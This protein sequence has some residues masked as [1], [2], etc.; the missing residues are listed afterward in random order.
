MLKTRCIAA[1]VA[2]MA[3][4]CSASA[5]EK[6]SKV[7]IYPSSAEQRV[8]LLGLLEIDHF[9][10]GEGG[11]VSEISEHDVAKL[12]LTGVK[13]KVLDEDVARSLKKA[14][15][16]FFAARKKGIDLSE[17]RVAFEQA[18]S[19]IDKII[20][21][22]ADFEVKSTFGGYYSFAEMESAMDVLVTKYSTIAEKISIGNTAEGRDLWLI[23]IS[24][25]VASDELNEPEV[26]Y[27]GL[28]HAREAITGASMI[29]FMQ[30]LCE[31]YNTD[32][33]IKDLVDHREFYII[34]CFNPDGWEYNR[35][36]GGEGSGWRKNRSKID[37]SKQ[38]Q[39]YNYEYGVD[40]N[41]NWGVDWG[42]CGSPILGSSTSCG[43]GSATTESDT[44]YGSR[45][46]SELETQAVRNFTK[47]HHIVAGFDQHAYGP[48]YSLPFGRKSLGHTMPQ[49]GKDFFTSIPALM[50]AY[51]GMRA[52]DS[53][54]A[55]GY[56]V[57][58]GF[59]DWMLM[60]EIGVGTKDTVWAMTGEGAAGGGTGGTYGSFWAPASQ[61]VYLSKGMCYQNLQLAYAAGTYVDIQ[62]AN[63]IAL[64]ALSGNLNFTVKRLGLGNDPVTVSITPLENV[65][66]VGG[67]VNISDMTYYGQYNGSIAYQ[68]SPSLTNGQKV[69]FI[70]NVATAG[71]SYSDTIVKIYN[72]T[73]LFSD[74][75][76]GS[77]VAANWTVSGGWSYSS[78]GA[79]GGAKSLT[80]SPGSL[81]T[82]NS[83]RTARYNNTLDLSDAT[84]A[85]LTFWTKHRAENFRDKLQVQVSTNNG[86]SW[87]PVAG[88]TTVQEPG[89]LD[90]STLNGQPALTGVRDY[91]TQE[92]FDLSAYKAPLQLQFV[93]TSDGDVSSF[94]FEKD[95]GFYIDDLK[96]IKSTA[97][98]T[99]LPVNFI[100]FAGKL[101]QNNTVHLWWEAQTDEEHLYFEVE[102]S[103]DGI[104]FS[105]LG[106]SSP[107]PPYQFI[108]TNPRFGNNIYR[109][110]QV[111]KDGKVTY[112]KTIN[113]A[114]EQ[115][116]SAVLYPNPVGDVLHI[117]L[118]AESSEPVVIKI[119]DLQGKEVYRVHATTLAGND[120]K[121]DVSAWK[122]QFYIATLYSS[123]DEVIATQKF[124]KH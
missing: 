50:G 31:N 81:Y 112:S 116:I 122:P 17:S 88:R 123:R 90:G 75:M 72:P 108:D 111:D 40:L 24:D 11:I 35:L 54:D 62:D 98:F 39:R 52:A 67:V 38:G 117:K 51:N 13:H 45:A 18:G 73:V 20:K 87:I 124:V 63:D 97:V 28:Q 89:T 78:D 14:N 85:Y 61:I 106:K 42:N 15:A 9:M 25:N 110:K 107:L 48:Y 103:P 70:W 46:F 102:R 101:L 74:N 7:I 12:K 23:K 121:I 80:E 58:G 41:R 47:S 43:S 68:L 29:F 26:L 66:S 4:V 55:L 91:W 16:R 119:T 114:L 33:R 27:M 57:A 21:K 36:N 49:K 69:R 100:S 44:Y 120:L 19:T 83:I 71:Y 32:P 30:Y 79:Y 65:Q 93:F 6:Y 60:G 8:H 53:Y 10:E 118:K 82:A 59:K 1:V 94:K 92:V 86:S 56:E 96:V 113:I 2:L 99:P 37:S 5:Q 64:I 76:E 105:S 22:P 115:Q 34:P 77:N 104:R 3:I 109:I 84:A 95:D